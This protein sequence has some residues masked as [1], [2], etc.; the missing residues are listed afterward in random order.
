MKVTLSILKA[1][2]GSIGGHITPSEQLVDEVKTFVQENGKNL[3]IDSYIGY[4]GDDIAILCTHER[5]FL[6]CTHE[7]YREAA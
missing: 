2:I 7:Y 4:I 1:D 6:D 3:I 5:G